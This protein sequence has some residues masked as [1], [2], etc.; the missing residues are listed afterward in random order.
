MYAKILT[1][2]S[3]VLSG[4]AASAEVKNPGD[5]V[6]RMCATKIESIGMVEMHAVLPKTIC[7]VE[8]IGDQAQYLQID[9]MVHMIFK[10]PNQIVLK[11][12]GIVVKGALTRQY[13]PGQVP[14]MKATQTLDS[15]QYES[16]GQ[17]VRA[18]K[19]QIVST[20]MRL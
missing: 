1:C 13:F 20:T 14:F 8:V 3:L 12:V 7:Y 16:T 10:T 2:L 18:S 15:I 11:Q 9:S 19:F 4:L 17:T 5:V 6:P